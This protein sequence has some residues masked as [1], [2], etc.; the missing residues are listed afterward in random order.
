MDGFPDFTGVVVMPDNTVVMTGGT[1][2]DN[3]TGIRQLFYLNDTWISKDE[4]YLWTEVNISSGYQGREAPKTVIMPDGSIVLVAGHTG[5]QT[6]NG[7]YKMWNDTWR[8]QPARIFRSFS[9]NWL[10]AIFSK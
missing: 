8:M 9:P 3:T 2:I 1:Y 5:N 4:G 7:N 6:P 10:T